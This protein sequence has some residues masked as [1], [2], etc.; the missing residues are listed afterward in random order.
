MRP[1]ACSM[2]AEASGKRRRTIMRFARGGSLV[3]EFTGTI[4]GGALVGLL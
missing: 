4:G 3:F 1:S 2:P